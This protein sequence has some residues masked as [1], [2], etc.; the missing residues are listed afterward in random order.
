MGDRGGCEDN[1]ICDD[2]AFLLI[3]GEEDRYSVIISRL[4]D[5]GYIWTHPE[6]YSTCTN[7]TCY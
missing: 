1:E 6:Y 3:T 5:A 4:V 2:V 7:Y